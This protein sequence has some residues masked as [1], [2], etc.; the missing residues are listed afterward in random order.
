MDDAPVTCPVL[1][2]IRAGRVR[3]ENLAPRPNRPEWLVP[4]TWYSFF[5]KPLDYGGVVF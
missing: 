3:L 2:C 5:V 4:G 1:L